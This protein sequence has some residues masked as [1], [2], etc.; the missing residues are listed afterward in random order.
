MLFTSK[1]VP[2]ILL[3]KIIIQNYLKGHWHSSK[4]TRT[5]LSKMPV[6]HKMNK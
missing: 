4:K 2:Y 3:S 5:S 6:G 1:V